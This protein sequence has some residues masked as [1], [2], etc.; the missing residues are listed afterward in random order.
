MRV[1]DSSLALPFHTYPVG[2][3]EKR[4]FDVGEIKILRCEI[5]VVAEFVDGTIHRL[6]GAVGSK[7]FFRE[8]SFGAIR[9]PVSG[10]ASWQ[11]VLVAAHLT[12]VPAC[13]TT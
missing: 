5:L 7:F 8:I 11:A 3:A 12:V 6:L 13:R 10:S 2:G 1:S 4:H 9:A